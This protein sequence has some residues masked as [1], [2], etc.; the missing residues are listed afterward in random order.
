MRLQY[1]QIFEPL[2]SNARRTTTT[3]VR[4]RRGRVRP[5]CQQNTGSLAHQ[6]PT[7]L[8]R[9]REQRRPTKKDGGPLCRRMLNTCDYGSILVADTFPFLSAY[10]QSSGVIPSDPLPTLLLCF[11]FWH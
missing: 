11:S 9:Q 10:T 8:H 1:S 3:R 5:Q 6:T 7:E 2:S 4:H